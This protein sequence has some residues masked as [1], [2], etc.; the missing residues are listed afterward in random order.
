MLGFH[1]NK[2]K[3]AIHNILFL[4]AHSDDIEIGC[5]GTIIRLVE[6]YAHLNILWIVF[7]SSQSRSEE[8]LN[9]ANTLLSNVDKKEIIVKGFRES[10]FPFIGT[11]IK[12]YFEEI[13]SEISPDIIFTHYRQ[14]LHQDHR[15]ISDLTWNTFRD[16][17]ILEYEIPKYDGDLGS[18]NFFTHLNLSICQQKIHHILS[19]FKT[20]TDKFWFTEETFLALL[21]LRGIEARSP[22]NFAE[23][24]YCRKLIF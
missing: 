17:L 7:G 23:A 15:L 2:E 13:S 19:H 1:F 3:D 6:E 11:E 4:G 14:D 18:P 16:N 20:Q 10:F 21:R 24:F 9:S 22:K 12:E 5:G 8:A